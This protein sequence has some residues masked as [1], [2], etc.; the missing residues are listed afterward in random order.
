MPATCPNCNSTDILLGSWWS[1]CNDCGEQWRVNAGPRSVLAAHEVA[2]PKRR[3]P[4][5][6]ASRDAA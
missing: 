5:E 4:V 2:R 6:P 3:R 1:T